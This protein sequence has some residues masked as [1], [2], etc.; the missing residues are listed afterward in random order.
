MEYAFA[1]EEYPE[2]V[3]SEY[4]DVMAIVVNGQNC[5]VVPETGQPISVNTV[6]EFTNSQYYVD[7]RSGAVGFNTSF[8][9]LTRNLR[10]EAPV[11]PGV[12]VE[13]LIAVADTGDAIYDSAVALVE[14]GIYSR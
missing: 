10:C 4:N 9:G 14:G 6:N 7:N 11:T 13:V 12:P 3:G 1:S 8:D 2:Y 5:A